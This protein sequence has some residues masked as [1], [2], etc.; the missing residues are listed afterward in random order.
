MR[1]SGGLAAFVHAEQ[2]HDVCKF[3]G[4]LHRDNVHTLRLPLS[5]VVEQYEERYVRNVVRVLPVSIPRP[6]A[7]DLPYV[8]SHISLRGRAL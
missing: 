2:L 3:A 1:H 8:S 4:I 7:L 5:V 6:I